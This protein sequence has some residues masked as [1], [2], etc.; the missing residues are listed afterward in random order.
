MP[1]TLHVHPQGRAYFRYT[2]ETPPDFRQLREQI[3]F[4]S[5]P[6]IPNASNQIVFV[7]RMGIPLYVENV[8]AKPAD[9]RVGSITWSRSSDD[10][11]L[12][13]L[14][15]SNEGQRNIRPKGFVEVRSPHG[16]FSHT[17]PFNPG[18]EPLL[19][20]QKRDW[21]ISFSLVPSGDLSVRLRFETSPRTTF[22]QQYHLAGF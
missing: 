13:T 21:P 18:N 8:M 11:L 14:V 22:D 12:L 10:T 7:P 19:P 17:F 1:L 15:A 6:V 16:K 2:V 3:F 4:S 9:I 5:T 20:G